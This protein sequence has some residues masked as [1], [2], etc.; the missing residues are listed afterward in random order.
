[1]NTKLHAIYSL[2]KVLLTKKYLPMFYFNEIRN[3]GDV[4]NED[5]VYFLTGRRAIKFSGVRYIRHL[6]AVGSVITAMNKKT[7]VWGSGLISKE[8][9][10]LIHEI[11]D[12]RAVRGHFTKSMLEHKFDVNLN[13]PLGDP[14]LLMPLICPGSYEKKHKFGLVLHYVDKSHSIR[15]IAQ[16]C[17]GKIIDVALSTNEFIKEL[18]SCEIILSSSMHGLILSDAYNIPN[19]RLIL[20]DKIVGGDFKFLDYYSTTNNP[21]PDS[22]KLGGGVSSEDVEYAISKAT[23]KYYKYDINHLKNAFPVEF[24][25]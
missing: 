9:I 16:N 7:I 5:I 8:A 17:G 18:T 1:M 21:N 11:G 19:T 10:N 4:V 3:I 15:D 23:V 22:V 2:A 12:I 6:S 20:S 25:H 13:V 24:T 14:A